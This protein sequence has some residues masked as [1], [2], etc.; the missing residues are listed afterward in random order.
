[1]WDMTHVLCEYV[2]YAWI[3]EFWVCVS[4]WGMFLVWIRGIWLTPKT[5]HVWIIGTWL[6]F[7]VNMQDMT[8]TILFGT[9]EYVGHVSCVVRLTSRN[10]F[11]VS[12]WDI[13]EHVWICRTWNKTLIARFRSSWKPQKNPFSIKNVDNI[14]HLSRIEKALRC[15][16]QVSFVRKKIKKADYGVKL[17]RKETKPIVVSFILF[18]KTFGRFLRIHTKWV[19]KKR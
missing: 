14:T 9:C 6:T 17:K 19:P 16:L 7:C 4:M 15:L 8:K 18:Y 1:M 5:W 13:Y 2:R 3:F 10:M 11:C 12:K